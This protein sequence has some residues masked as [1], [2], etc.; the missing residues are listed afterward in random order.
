[1]VE[2]YSELDFGL[3]RLTSRFHQEWAREQTAADVVVDH[4]G[5]D[6]GAKAAHAILE[7]V[8]RLRESP[9]PNWALTALWHA[10]TGRTYDLEHLGIDGRDWLRQIADICVEQ[11]RIEDA[12]YVVAIP[13]PA[14]DSLTG[15]VLDELLVAGP[16]LTASAMTRRHYEVSGV[17]PALELAVTQVSPDLGFRLFLRAMA[18]YW[19]PIDQAWYERFEALGERFGYGPLHVVDVAFLTDLT[20]R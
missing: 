12:T 6:G 4:A 1:M 10:A 9:L 17:V 14:D 13:A 19:V 3:T 8:I 11:I 2:R 16:G 15:A 18:E 7:D 5:V 20:T